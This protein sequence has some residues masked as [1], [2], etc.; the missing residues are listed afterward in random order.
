MLLQSMSDD[1]V[2][3]LDSTRPSS[4][5]SSAGIHWKMVLCLGMTV[6][7]SNLGGDIEATD[8]RDKDEEVQGGMQGR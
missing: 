1:D 8:S 3:I 2:S 6:N 5:S 7:E 4:L